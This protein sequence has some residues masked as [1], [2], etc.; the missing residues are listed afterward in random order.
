MMVKCYIRHP[1]RVV[2]N[3]VLLTSQ[4]RNG[5]LWSYKKKIISRIEI[6]EFSGGL[7]LQLVLSTILITGEGTLSPD[8]YYPFF[9]LLTI[10][11]I[12]EKV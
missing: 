2:Y 4:Y 8:S 9:G 11:L 1:G 6:S 12:S 3:S 5:K 7:C 10:C